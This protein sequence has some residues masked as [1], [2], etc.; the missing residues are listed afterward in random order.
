ML[1]QEPVA[2]QF[3]ISI[4][5]EQAKTYGVSASRILSLLRSAYSQNYLYLIK[6]PEDQ[7]QVILEAEDR[8]RT[9]NNFV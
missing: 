6:K 5:R 9:R 3:D 2:Q 8:A 4:R 1:I 7:Y